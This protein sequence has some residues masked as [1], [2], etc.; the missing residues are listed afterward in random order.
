MPQVGQRTKAHGSYAVRHVVAALTY[1][2]CLERRRRSR[3]CGVDKDGMAYTILV[4]PTPPI[5]LGT[6]EVQTNNTSTE[7]MVGRAS[8]PMQMSHVEEQL[9]GER[10]AAGGGAD[11][12]RGL[13]CLSPPSTSTSPPAARVVVT[14]AFSL[15]CYLL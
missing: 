7:K 4:G 2:C 6:T 9:V 12:G 1:C 15:F 3:M 14:L 13:V 5:A 10:L 8:R 11:H